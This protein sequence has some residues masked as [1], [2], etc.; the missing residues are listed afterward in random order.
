MNSSFASEPLA[1]CYHCGEACDEQ[2]LLFE[3]KIFCCQGC[4][5]VYE[6]ISEN[7]LCEFYHIED[8]P[9]LSQKNNRSRANKFDY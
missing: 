1:K 5:L 8:N 3:D 9:G 7:N 6:V 2:K 4:R